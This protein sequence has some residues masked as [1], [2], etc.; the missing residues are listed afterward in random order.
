MLSQDEILGIIRHV[1][2][3]AG[4]ALVTTGWA[5]NGQVQDAV[6]ALMVLGGIAWSI[7]QKRTAKAVNSSPAP[8]KP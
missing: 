2:T 6:G 5:T 4:G 1:L 7:Y 3:S 8:S